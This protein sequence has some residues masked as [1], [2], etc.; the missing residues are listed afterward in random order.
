MSGT[1]GNIPVEVLEERLEGSWTSSNHRGLLEGSQGEN[2][3]FFQ[4]K[5]KLIEPGTSVSSALFLLCF[6]SILELFGILYLCLF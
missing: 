1:P 5:G 4:G 3:L 6:E 2:S